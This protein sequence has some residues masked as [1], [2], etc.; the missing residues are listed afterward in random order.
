M[1][2][3]VSDL[4]DLPLLCPICHALV[5]EVSRRPDRTLYMDC[6]N[7]HTVRVSVVYGTITSELV[8]EPKA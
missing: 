8:P 6:P 7:G 3:D 2:S 1:A 4:P 5:A